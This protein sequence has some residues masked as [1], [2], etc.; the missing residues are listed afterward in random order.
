M[1]RKVSRENAILVLV[2]NPNIKEA[3]AACGISEKTMHRW[4]HEPE[5]A[6]QLAEAQR[7]VA[8]RVTRLVIS[9]AEKAVGV[10]DTIMSDVETAPPA[11]VSA[12]KAILEY[13]MRAIETE[14][15]LARLEALEQLQID[16]RKG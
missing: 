3:A 12:A 6:A 8:K 5:F 7:Y 15:V 13:A 10:L 1:G 16:D 9:R 4:L 14:D 11:R 2:A